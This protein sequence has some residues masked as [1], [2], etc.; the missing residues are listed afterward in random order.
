MGKRSKPIK[1]KKVLTEKDKP[2]PTQF[3]CL[4]CNHERSITVKIDKKGGVGTLSCSVCGQR[5]QTS[6]NYLSMAVDVYADWVDACE[7]VRSGK[8]PGV[9]AGM[10]MSHGK[11]PGGEGIMERRRS[12]V[13]EDEDEDVAADLFDG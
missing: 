9:D 1:I 11:D 2:L 7:M 6:I 13:E 12:F 4:F 8:A 3:A 5:Y 10:D